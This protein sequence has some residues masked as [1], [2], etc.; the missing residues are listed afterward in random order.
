MELA[1][2]RAISSPARWSGH[3][4]ARI[5]FSLGKRHP[6]L[7]ATPSDLPG[8][9]TSGA[10]RAARAMG[11][12]PWGAY[13]NR[14]KR[15]VVLGAPRHG[16]TRGIRDNLTAD[17][18][19][20]WFYDLM[21]H[22]Y[23]GPGRLA[24]TVPQMEAYPHFLRHTHS[25]LVILPSPGATSDARIIKSDVSRINK[26]A[27][28][29]RDLVLVYDEMQVHRRV[30]EGEINSLFANGNHYG[31]VPIAAGQYATCIPLGARKACSDA[32][33]YAEHHHKELA[34]IHD[35]Y[36]DIFAAKV[37]QLTRGDMPL[38]WREDDRA[39]W[40]SGRERG[41]FRG[42]SAPADLKESE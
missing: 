31:I 18:E 34:E 23:W 10:Q 11:K 8:G 9:Q 17:S 26:L 27:R 35:C 41:K 16:K 36:G 19:R 39:K 21:E 1:L 28:W 12:Q 3:A 33:V 29:A 20:C 5:N 14:E 37:N 40:W 25:R 15:V 13:L 30:D 24:I 7:V 42:K 22:D 2:P 38:H 4:L 32:Y 6:R